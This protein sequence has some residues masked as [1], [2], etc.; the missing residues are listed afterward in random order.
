M[1]PSESSEKPVAKILAAPP[2][3]EAEQIIQ[4][5]LSLEPP[6]IHAA[7]KQEKYRDLLKGPAKNFD[8][9][10]RVIPGKPAVPYKPQ[11]S[12]GE[13]SPAKLAEDWARAT[14]KKGR[15]PIGGAQDD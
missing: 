10:K 13:V 1:P 14:D 5:D 4:D 6:A 2:N 3:F 9:E 11:Y 12:P 7:N 15:P 8:P